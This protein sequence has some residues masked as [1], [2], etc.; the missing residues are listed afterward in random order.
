MAYRLNLFSV[1]LPTIL[2]LAGLSTPCSAQLIGD[3]LAQD[4]DSVCRDTTLSGA[5][6]HG[7]RFEA[8]FRT[9]VRFVLDP[10]TGPPN[11][12]GWTIKVL[13]EDQNRDYLLVATPPYRFSNPRYLDT[14]YGNTAEQV[15]AWP[16]R[17]FHFVANDSAHQAMW[18]AIGVLLWPANHREEELEAARVAMESSAKRPGTF[19]ILSSEL[20]PPSEDLPM[21]RIETL[22]FEVDLCVD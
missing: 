18:E 10:T 3:G 5:V 16:E 4:P 7:E 2:V 20:L 12:D 11:P 13:G 9:G 1:A 21:G 14:S 6:S 19:R 17:R 8:A 15:V 22:E